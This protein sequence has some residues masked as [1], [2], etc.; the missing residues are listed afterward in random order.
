MLRETEIQTVE[1]GDG[2]IILQG[3]QSGRAFSWIIEEL[4]GEGTLTVSSLEAGV[5]VFTVCTTTENL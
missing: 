4:T 2:N 1:R 5:T 3:R